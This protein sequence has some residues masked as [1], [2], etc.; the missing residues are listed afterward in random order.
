MSDTWISLGEAT[1]KVINSIAEKR[2]MTNTLTSQLYDAWEAEKFDP[3]LAHAAAIEITR[4]R[5][6]IHEANT[7]FETPEMGTEKWVAALDQWQIS[8]I[9]VLE[10]VP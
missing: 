3:A 9:D 4:L 10:A 2:T 1:A 6:K 8:V 5:E 7:L